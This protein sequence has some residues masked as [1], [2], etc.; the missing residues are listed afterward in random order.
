MTSQPAGKPEASILDRVV[1]RIE[2][3]WVLVAYL[4]I[5]A[6][7]F[8]LRFWDLGARALHH[9]ESIHAV[10]A[11]NLAQEGSYRHSPTFHGPLLYVVQAF[12]FI[13][14]T[15]TDY[16]SRISPA[17]FGMLVVAAPLALRRWLGSTGALAAVAFLAFSPTLVYFSRFL[18]M[19]IYLAA[20]ILAMVVAVWSY[21]HDGRTRWLIVL[22]VALTLAYTT[23]E[24]AFLFVAFLLLYLNGHLALDLAS[25]SLRPRGADTTARRLSRAALLYPV[26]WVIA[27]LWPFLAGLRS[28]LA[29]GDLPRTGDLLVLSGT[30]TLPLLTPFARELLEAVFATDPL[31]Y[32]RQASDGSSLPGVC[33]EASLRQGL[34]LGF[35]FAVTTVVAAVAGLGW[36]ARTWLVA[37][38]V[39][40]L[41]YATLM[42]T[43]WTNPGGVCSG[44]WGSIDYWQAQQDVRRGMQPWFYYLMV[45][46]AY[47]FLPL[48]LALAGGVWALFRGTAFARFLV[49]WFLVLFTALSFAGEKMPW[50]NTHL[51]IPAALLAA[52][53]L[54]RAWSYWQPSRPTLPELFAI[55][56]VLAMSALALAALVFEWGPWLSLRLGLGLAAILMAVNGVVFLASRIGPR[57]LP[58]LAALTVVASLAYFSVQTMLAVSFERG[59]VP[60]DMLIYTQSSPQI[61]RLADDIDALADASG[62]GYDLRIAVDTRSSFAWPWEWYLRDYRNVWR[63]NFESGLPPGDFDVVLVNERNHAVVARDLDDGAFARPFEYPHRWWYPETYKQALAG[64]SKDDDGRRGRPCEPYMPETWGKIRS[65]LFGGSWAKDAFL[66]WRDHEA[67]VPHGSTDGFVPYGSIDGFA[68]FPSGFDRDTGRLALEPVPPGFDRAGRPAFGGTGDLPGQFTAPVDIAAGPDGS[69]YVVDRAARLLQKFDPGGNYLVGIKLRDTASQDSGPWGLAVAPDGTVYVADTFGWRILAFDADLTH[70]LLA[71][72]EA[73][74]RDGAPPGAYSLFGPRDLAI[75]A[76]GNLWVT[77]TGHHRIVV[78]TSAGEFLR[79]IKGPF[80]PDVNYQGS[81]FGEFSEPVGI[82]IAPNGEIVIA[83]MWN[84]RVQVLDASGAWLREFPV[85]GWGGLEA[86]DKPYLTVLRDGRIAVSLPSLGQVRIY[87]PAGMLLTTIAPIDEPLLFPYGIVETPGGKLWIVEGGAARVRLFD[88]T[89]A[90]ER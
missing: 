89:E 90:G 21:L 59:D 81:G 24:A 7:A 74:L 82:D 54:Q 19:D 52:W 49:V 13:V 43:F 71:F 39:A 30:L 10:W 62:K 14:F 88:S 36:R 33:D 51:A 79:E 3:N 85:V 6:A 15:A 56:F 70:R 31:D 4:A 86:L 50:L 55:A 28:R 76:D 60:D 84:A 12:T 29:W 53:T 37:A 5:F 18:R 69:L 42:T 25:A 46:P 16:T 48:I 2:A 83:D 77:D 44:A 61:T 23:K 64:C 57:I 40:A 32:W 20:F 58:V 66:Y 75:D 27:A 63:T 68:Y 34:V 41:I 17:F 72:G 65:G 11:W 26:A 87:S 1:R 47:E 45:M 22:A 78:Y 80:S 35:G 9:D 67:P 73:P 38:A 8:A